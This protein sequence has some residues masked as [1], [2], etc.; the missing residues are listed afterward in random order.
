MKYS[1]LALT[2][3]VYLEKCCCVH[4]RRYVLYKRIFDKHRNIQA[5][6]NREVTN[7]QC[8]LML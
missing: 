8:F 5:E 4:H 3:I 1:I 6:L 2:P 7:K